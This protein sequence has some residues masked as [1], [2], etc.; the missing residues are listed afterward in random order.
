MHCKTRNVR[1]VEIRAN[2][3]RS[4]GGPWNTPP[5]SDEQRTALAHMDATTTIYLEE[6]TDAYPRSSF[7]LVV[8][9]ENIGKFP[10]VGQVI[11]ADLYLNKEATA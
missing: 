11:P 3:G 8:K 1:V 10:T 6:D 4:G 9:N 7:S 2:G 5:A